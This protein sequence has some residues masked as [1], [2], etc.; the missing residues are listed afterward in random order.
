MTIGG[1]TPKPKKLREDSAIMT[2]AI[3]RVDKTIIEGITLGSI[4]INII[5]EKELLFYRQYHT[6]N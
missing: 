2:V 1:F 5:M 4:W 3:C 6:R